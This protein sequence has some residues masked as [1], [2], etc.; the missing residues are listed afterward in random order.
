M[1]ELPDYSFVEHFGHAITSY[2]PRAVMLDY[3][4]GWARKW[5]LEVT[6]NRK[7]VSVTFLDADQKFLVVSEDTADGCRYWSYFDSVIVC[8]GHFSVP[9][10]IPA[11]PG[12]EHFPGSVIH[13]H[14]FRDAKVY[15]GKRLLV[16]G[17]GYSGE[18]IAMQCCKFGAHSATVCHQEAMG[19]MGHDFGH[20]P[21][22][23]A[24][25]LYSLYCCRRSVGFEILF[26]SRPVAGP[27]L[28]FLAGCRKSF[29]G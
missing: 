13:S 15:A 14:N 20:M 4:Q 21:V 22:C 8:T 26:A 28:Y 6:L 5:K 7:V 12:M 19:P 16:I 1:L 25:P 29:A 23:T 17:N 9:N 24:N 10:Y 2:P 11:Y 3:L 27:Q 18:D